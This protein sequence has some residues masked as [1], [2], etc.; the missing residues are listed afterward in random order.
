MPQAGA[1][2]LIVSRDGMTN[3]SL[4]NGWLLGHSGSHGLGPHQSACDPERSCGIAIKPPASSRWNEKPAGN[5][6]WKVK[7]LFLIQP[8]GGTT[9]WNF[10]RFRRH[11]DAVQTLRKA[12]LGWRRGLLQCCRHRPETIEGRRDPTTAGLALNPPAPATPGP[13]IARR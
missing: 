7:R 11:D 4:E 1:S 2:Q 8:D 12:A 13:F 6:D 3:P 10:A 5:G 9:D